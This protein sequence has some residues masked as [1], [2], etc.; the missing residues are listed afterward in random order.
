MKE[1]KA[2][3]L[4]PLY[5]LCK[6]KI[7]GRKQKPHKQDGIKKRFWQ[8]RQ[9]LDSY[10]EINY[11]IRVPKLIL[12]KSEKLLTAYAKIEPSWLKV[13]HGIGLLHLAIAYKEK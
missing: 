7:Q 5:S 8:R 2:I 13:L 6:K 4:S 1:Y 3:F 11:I 9:E 10:V 12:N